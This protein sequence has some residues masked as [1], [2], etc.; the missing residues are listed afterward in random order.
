MVIRG[1]HFERAKLFQNNITFLPLPIQMQSLFTEGM[2]RSHGNSNFNSK[3]YFFHV[4][5]Q[6]KTLTF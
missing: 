3:D 4:L 1:R 2:M 5:E 6:K